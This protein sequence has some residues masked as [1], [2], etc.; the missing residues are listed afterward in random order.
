[1]YLDKKSKV[2]LKWQKQPMIFLSFY[3]KEEEEMGRKERPD[4][5]ARGVLVFCLMVIGLAVYALS[6]GDLGGRSFFD[7]WS[8]SDGQKATITAEP[9]CQADRACFGIEYS[10]KSSEILGPVVFVEKVI[11]G[12]P[13]ERAGLKARD[14]IVRIDGKILGGRHG[15]PVSIGP[16][17]VLSSKHPGDQ[18]TMEVLR[19]GE[20]LIFSPVLVRC[21]ELHK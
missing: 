20:I 8:W 12:S 9:A 1:V 10:M 14:I 16:R 3:Q 11:P 18:I 6:T 7:S 4:Y 2:V 21:S 13:A 19:H 15:D 5:L 17:Y